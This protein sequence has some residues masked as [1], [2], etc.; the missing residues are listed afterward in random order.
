MIYA[1]T[2]GF[3][4]R[5]KPYTYWVMKGISKAIRPGGIRS[6]LSGHVIRPVLYLVATTSTSARAVICTHHGPMCDP[7]RGTI[8]T[9][10]T[11]AS[12]WEKPSPD[13]GALGLF[14]R[15]SDTAFFNE[16][17]IDIF[18]DDLAP[19]I[20]PDQ[21]AAKDLCQLGANTVMRC[22]L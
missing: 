17:A 5:V 19:S 22:P 1:M 18:D 21:L 4:L 2:A 15:I 3:N 11:Q 10:T 13:F 7:R 16:S 12:K 20:A 8:D 14:A 6:H 9:H